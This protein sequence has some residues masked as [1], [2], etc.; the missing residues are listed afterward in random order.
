M[1]GYDGDGTVPRTGAAGAFRAYATRVY[2]RPALGRFLT[3]GLIFS[4]FSKFPTVF[5]SLLRSCAYRPVLG[6]MGKRCLIENGVRFLHSRRTFLGDR[7]FIGER[8]FLDVGP[9]ASAIRIG[10]D[11][12]IGRGVVLR[13]QGDEIVVGKNV[14]ISTYA[15]LYCYGGIE[16]GD[17]CMIA[18]HVEIVGGTHNYDDVTTPMRLQGRSPSRIVIGPDCW[19]GSHAVIMG[20]ATI[21]RGSIIG[22]GAVV[23]KD[24]PEYSI[25]VGIPARVVRK[26]GKE[27]QETESQKDKRA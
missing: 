4:L 25:A 23:H 16:I 1:Q 7:V 3:D 17:D 8:S 13:T 19:I 24:I 5:G 9:A 2:G 14:N 26:R 10:D 27:K 18:Q 12:H 20:N 15:L 21:G 22:A 6:A 11:G